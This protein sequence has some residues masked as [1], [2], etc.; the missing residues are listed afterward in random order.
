MR[1]YKFLIGNKIVTINALNRVKAYS[2]VYKAYPITKIV[3]PVFICR[4][5]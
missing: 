1:S 5:R 3:E 4:V 2:E